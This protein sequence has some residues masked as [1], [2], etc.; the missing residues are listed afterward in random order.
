M[1]RIFF[2]LINRV[3]QRHIPIHP[4]TYVQCLSWLWASDANVDSNSPPK[5]SRLEIL[6]G[7]SGEPIQFRGALDENGSKAEHV[8]MFFGSGQEKQTKELARLLRSAGMGELKKVS[9]YLGAML[10]YT[11]SIAITIEK[12]CSMATEAFYSMKGYGRHS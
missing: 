6:P 7:A 12:R 9:R 5:Q 10:S 4:P 1:P 3:D 2:G 11:G 8:A